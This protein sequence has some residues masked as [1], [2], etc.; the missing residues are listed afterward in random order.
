MSD[1]LHILNVQQ[2]EAS[3]PVLT[4]HLASPVR[5]P[6]IRDL[7]HEEQHSSS[8]V[9]LVRRD[10]GDDK[11]SMSRRSSGMFLNSYPV[12]DMLYSRHSQV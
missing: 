9:G 7:S 8:R 3:S 10:T 4:D 11:S 12:S 2:T 1:T 6:L 5:P